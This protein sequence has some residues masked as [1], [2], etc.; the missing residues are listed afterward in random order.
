MPQQPLAQSTGW[1]VVYIAS[2]EPEAYIIVGRLETEG[3]KAFVH[4]EPA[5]RAYGLTIG[6]LGE[7][8]VLVSPEDYDQATAILDQDA[9]DDTDMVPDDDADDDWDEEDD[10]D[11]DEDYEDADY[12]DEDADDEYEGDDYDDDADE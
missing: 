5:G 3:I 11:A 9:D 8:T 1:M 2:S 7:I 6:T 12:D 10:E 4:Q